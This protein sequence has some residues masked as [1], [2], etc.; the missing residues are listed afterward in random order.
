MTLLQLKYFI[1]VAETGNFTHAAKEV[2]TSQP[3]ISRQ[4]QLLEEELG[5]ALFN[6]NSKPIRLT[7]PGQILYEGVKEAITDINYTLDMAEIASEGKSGSLSISFQSGYYSE[8]MFFPIINELRETWSSLQIRC[9]KLFS[10]E[11]IKALKNES[12]D[13]AI[14]LDFPHWEKSS[15]TVIPLKKVETLIVMSK[16][17]RLAN[18]K[19]LEYNDLCGETFFLTAPNGYQVDK[20]FKDRFDLTN[21]HQ[22]EVTSSEIAYFKVLSDNGLTISN[23]D[24]PT[25]LNSPHYHSIKFD[26]E[27]SDSYVCVVNL[28]NKNPVIKL[29]LDLINR[30]CIETEK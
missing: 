17:H 2:Y 5:Y 20:I 27:Y 24:D 21:V 26:S 13:I 4:I 8:Y 19:S 15:F 28:D 30:Y 7:E 10:W 18:K 14:G 29:F 6:R 23:P 16:H 22:V 3:T 12:V 11:Q 1:S 9:N 25:L